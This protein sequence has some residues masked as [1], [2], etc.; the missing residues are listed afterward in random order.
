VGSQTRRVNREYD[1]P[2]LRRCVVADIR[3]GGG[4]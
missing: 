1:E 3:R 4:E 2:R